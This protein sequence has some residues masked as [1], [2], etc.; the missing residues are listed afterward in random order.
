MVS[1]IYLQHTFYN[2][3]IYTSTKS[4]CYWYRHI[5]YMSKN[6]CGQIFS[7]QYIYW[8]SLNS[9][10]SLFGMWPLT[11]SHSTM[12]SSFSLSADVSRISR[13]VRWALW[14][15][16][17]TS[18]FCTYFKTRSWKQNQS[19]LEQILTKVIYFLFHIKYLTMKLQV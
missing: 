2:Y 18:L 12:L 1:M 11:L 10:L 7:L 13:L 3:K 17:K 15:R 16:M 4:V 6:K 14:Y 5:E 9:G 19:I 8:T